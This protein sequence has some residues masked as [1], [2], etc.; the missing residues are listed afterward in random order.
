MEDAFNR[1]AAPHISR[2]PDNDGQLASHSRSTGRR[3]CDY[4]GNAVA[5]ESVV[6]LSDLP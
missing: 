4:I 3:F 6:W 1:F 5:T 2:Q